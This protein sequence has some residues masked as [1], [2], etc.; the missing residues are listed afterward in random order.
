MQSAQSMAR[1]TLV[2]YAPSTSVLHDLATTLGIDR[3]IVQNQIDTAGDRVGRML[4]LGTNPF[5]FFNGSVQVADIAGLVRISPRLELEV[6]PKFL[7]NEW[8]RWREDFFYL[9]MLSRHG[10]LLANERL[11]SSI[12]ASEDLATLVARAMIVMF[13]E[14]YRRP[15]RTYRFANIEDFAI[16]GEVD[17]ESIVLPSVDGF[18]QSVSS[19]DRRN[20]FNAAILGA[21]QTLLTKVRDPNTRRQLVRVADVLAPQASIS[22]ANHRPVPSRAKRWQSL[23][24]LAIEVLRGFGVVYDAASLRAPGFVVETWRVWEDVL[25]LALRQFWGVG[26]VHIQPRAVLGERTTFD[27]NGNS[28]SSEAKVKPDIAVRHGS[29]LIVDA[30]YKG[31][32]GDTRSSI[33]KADLYEALAFA[34]A[35]TCQQVVLLYPAVAR[36]NDP[37][38]TG[39]TSLFERFDVD[40]TVVYGMEVEIRGISRT[41]AL[42]QLSN[43][44]SRSLAPLLAKNTGLA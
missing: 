27:A 21:T 15:L 8:P 36:G 29:G 3:S 14:N 42:R 33:S 7:G 38:P 11:G 12:G 16:D 9:A 13:W 39:T 32:F 18:Q 26:A 43:G 44:L 37:R 10:R 23:H 17:P 4:G 28:S 30:K 19:Y 35:L 5:R 1:A 41:G 34:R 24:D 2:E 40:T 25:T 20:I 22:R 6:A 31:N